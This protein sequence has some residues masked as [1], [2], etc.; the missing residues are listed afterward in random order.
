MCV[1]VC[2]CVCVS[3]CVCMYIS[4]LKHMY[5]CISLTVH[6]THVCMYAS[7]MTVLYTHFN[8]QYSTAAYISTVLP[9][10]HEVRPHIII[11]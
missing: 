3:V 9:G 10:L 1:C 2:V 7:I 11:Q 6:Y 8:H 5:H 4:E